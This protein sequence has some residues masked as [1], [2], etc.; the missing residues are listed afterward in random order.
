MKPLKLL[1]YL[2]LVFLTACQQGKSV[3]EKELELRERELKLKEKELDLK[4]QQ[5]AAP[6]TAAPVQ[7]QPAPVVNNTKYL[8]VVIVT[9]EPTV[10]T[11][12]KK[13]TNT[14]TENSLGLPEMMEEEQY[15]VPRIRKYT[16]EIIEVPNYSEDNMYKERDKFESRI[17]KQLQY[18][19]I[20]SS[21]GNIEATIM[22]RRA[23]VF[24]TY[25]EA[26]LSLAKE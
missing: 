21:Y 2:M 3:K 1:L 25:A 15:T 17:R 7:Q 8:Y 22:S 24:N 12:T 11:R 26:S 14:F 23:P 4:Q 13:H 20:S 18:S 5:S 19:N 16:S 10:A 9:N 6:V